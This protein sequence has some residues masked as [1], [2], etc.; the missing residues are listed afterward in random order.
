M[1]NP[2]P[3]LSQLS[4]IKKFRT[5][6]S[7]NIP[8]VSHTNNTLGNIFNK[9]ITIND[10]FNSRSQPKSDN[11]Y[12]QY[13]PRLSDILSNLI[14]PQENST[15]TPLSTLV[16]DIVSKQY[17]S[18]LQYEPVQDIIIYIRGGVTYEESRLVYE[19]G[20]SNKKINLI[21]GGDTIHNSESWL[22]NLYD[23]V[24]E[25]EEVG[26]TVPDRRT[27]LRDIL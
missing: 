24:N 27:Q 21:I 2:L 25:S 15:Q 22:N 4:L 17:G 14:T 7:S 6:F 10:F 19:L 11:V 16:P 9:K 23:L 20:K 5:L 1:T 18:N 26:N 12:M 13:V 8:P 3:T